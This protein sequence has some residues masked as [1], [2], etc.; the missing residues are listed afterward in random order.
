MRVLRGFIPLVLAL[1][2]ACAS[3]PTIRA[4]ADPNSDLGRYKTFGFFEPLATDRSGYS[5]LLST[6]L[7]DA[8]RREMEQR[9][10]RYAESS[11]DLRV[12]F[13]VKVK[14]R[15]E[16][17]SSADPGFRGFFRYRYGYYD[18]WAGYPYDVRTVNYTEGTLAIDLVDASRKQ[19][20]WQGLATG[21]VTEKARANPA[22]AIDD[23]VRRI[24][25][26]FPIKAA[27]A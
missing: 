12:N 2:A 21:T 10:Y 22:P 16:L 18:P 11:P 27:G 20:V 15:Q 6:R 25:A 24:F 23:A 5:T 7:K 3:G 13:Y 1:A 26:R 19:L 4:D 17:R 9:G 8:T 14:D